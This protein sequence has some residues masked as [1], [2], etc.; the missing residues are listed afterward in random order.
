MIH[1]PNINHHTIKWPKNTHWRAATCQEVYCEDFFKG[2]TIT[3]PTISV[4][5]D[6][7]RDMKNNVY[8]NPLVNLKGL[9]YRYTE[10]RSGDSLTTFKFDAFQP[11]LKQV[12]PGEGHRIKLERDP[13]YF[14]QRKEKEPVQWIDEYAEERY[15]IGRQIKGG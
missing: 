12:I 3:V 9:R 13:R 6:I 11:C 14:I 10:T 4:Q 8:G 2:W 15:Q 5:A 1:R 7:V